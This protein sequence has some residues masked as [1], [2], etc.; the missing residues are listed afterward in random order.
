MPAEM[1]TTEIAAQAAS[2]YLVSKLKRDH[3]A[4]DASMQQYYTTHDADYDTLCVSVALVPPS[5]GHA[6][7]ERRRRRA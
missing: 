1:R 4:H 2:L 5:R 6:P 3:P 7:F